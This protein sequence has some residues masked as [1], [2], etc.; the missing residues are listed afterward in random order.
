MASEAEKLT[1]L[2]L[3]DSAA[4]L[5]QVAEALFELGYEVHTATSVKQAQQKL[6]RAH[7]VI[8]DYHM[9]EM[10]GQEA[11]RLL[12]RG[13][14]DDTRSFYLYT[15][16]A[17]VAGS[18]K[19]LGFDGAFTWKGDMDMLAS[20]LASAARIHLMKRRIASMRRA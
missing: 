19:E 4:V 9:P 11:M 13:D 17:S 15:T 18:Y 20:Q 1:V 16:D 12:R 14:R 8:I 6:A 5:N 10:D 7:I 2:F 3:D